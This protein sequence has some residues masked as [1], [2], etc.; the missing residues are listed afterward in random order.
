[1][2]WRERGIALGLGALEV[3]TGGLS[4]QP[5]VLAHTKTVTIQFNGLPW[6]VETRA[7]DVAELLLQSV[8]VYENWQ[9]EP[10]PNTRLT[11]QMT[12]TVQDDTTHTLAANVS[13]NLVTEKAKQVQPEPTPPPASPPKPKSP[14][15]DGL[16]TW[17]SFG[18]QLTTA[19]RQFP[20]GTKLRVV[21]VNS[22]KTIDVVVNDYGPQ[23]HTGVA[24]DLNRPAFAQL[25]PLGAGKIQIKYYKL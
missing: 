18:D 17:Y 6:R 23:A 19:S 4:W 8:G 10:T 11:D 16:A 20:K 12:I 13:R 25:A 15:H 7:K 9:I 1:M 3:L 14:I 2:N 24:L 21:A 22:G 5:P